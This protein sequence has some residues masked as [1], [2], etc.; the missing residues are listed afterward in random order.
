MVRHKTDLVVRFNTD[1]AVRHK[2]D[3]VVRL[4]MLGS[5]GQEYEI[6]NKH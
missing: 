4:N 2:A 6:A 5:L 3:L 1:L